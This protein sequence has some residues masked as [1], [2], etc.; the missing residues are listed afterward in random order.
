MIVAPPSPLERAEWQAELELGFERVEARTVLCRRS[1]VGPVR[2]QRPFY[3]EGWDVCHVYVLHPPGGL[4]GG[5]SATL[6]IDLGE[7]AHALLTTPAATKFYRSNGRRARQSVRLRL[8]EGAVGEWL[9]QET[10]VFGGAWGESRTR[11]ELAGNAL[12]AGWETVCLGRPAAGDVYT[13][14]T[15]R[16]AFELWREGSPLW[17][18][19]CTFEASDR[20]LEAVWGLRGAPV[21]G[22]FVVSTARP[23][24]V[25]AIRDAVAPDSAH[26]CFSVTALRDVTVCRYSGESSQRASMCFTSAWQ[27]VRRELCGRPASI[28]RIWLT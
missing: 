19:R 5:D 22:S 12:F 18:D 28:P 13:S 1:H 3:P 27:V 6:N 4:V 23:G 10:I 17:I 8:T 20:V 11:V 21:F 7:R 16:T 26:E 2:V 24:L 25:Q 15:Y 9:P 14:G